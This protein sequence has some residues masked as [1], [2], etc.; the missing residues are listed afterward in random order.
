MPEVKSHKRKVGCKTCTVK[1][2][3]RKKLPRGASTKSFK[4]DKWPPIN[5]SGTMEYLIR[6]RNR[7]IKDI[8]KVA[9]GD[10]ISSGRHSRFI[11]TRLK[12][13]NKLLKSRKEE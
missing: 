8:Q 1:K 3:T 12:Q 10:F 6:Y 2:H 7:V 9:S 4:G 13:V 11:R 5:K